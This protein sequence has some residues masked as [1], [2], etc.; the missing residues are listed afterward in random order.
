MKK[1]LR[2]FLAA[3]LLPVAFCAM[4]CGKTEAVEEV[5]E[6]NAESIKAEDLVGTWK[7]VGE[8]ISTV[9]FGANG[10]YRDDAGGSLY[11][12]GTYFVDEI[13][14]TVTVKES[15]YGLVFVYDVELAGDYLTLQ[16]NG[17]KSRIF[18]RN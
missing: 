13:N 10:S 12:D 15:E 17:G 18:I 16:V 6:E 4:A 5:P 14:N 11:V 8:E 3:I 9:T 1:S 7:G 2:V